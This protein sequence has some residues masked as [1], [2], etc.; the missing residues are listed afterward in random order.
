MTSD[1]SILSYSLVGLFRL[2]QNL[3]RDFEELSEIEDVISEIAALPGVVSLL[4]LIRSSPA[5]DITSSTLLTSL[6]CPNDTGT[7]VVVPDLRRRRAAHEGSPH[8]DRQRRASDD[9]DD[10]FEDV[11]SLLRNAKIYFTPQDGD[12]ARIIK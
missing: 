5:S 12:S 6:V 9:I 1:I 3:A 10:T 2:Q 8:D 11:L 4:D 7:D